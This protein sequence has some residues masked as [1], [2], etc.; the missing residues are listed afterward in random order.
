VRV[1]GFQDTIAWYDQNA[2]Q[3]AEVNA[4]L[5]DIDQIEELSSLLPPSAAV[6]DAGCAAGRDSELFRQKGF[7]VTGVD[8]SGGLIG[9]GRQQFPEVNFV[10]ANF[11]ELPFPDQS[12]DAIW[13]H[14]SLLH[15]ETQDDVRKAL[16]EFHRV[17]RPEGK[18]LVLVK[19]QTGGDKTAVVAD[20][21]SGHNRFFQYFT[22]DEMQTLLTQAGFQP[23]KLEEYLE[24]DKRPD[25]RPE[26]G[27]IYSISGRV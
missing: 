6:L 27:L 10:Q 24:S 21:L 11:L 12:Y 2:G 7:Q 4:P 1:S 16:S 26:A 18:L 22:K 14:Q 23:Q 15:L 5:A 3:Y 9:V 19:A 20:S 13:A 8:I 17:L 25:G